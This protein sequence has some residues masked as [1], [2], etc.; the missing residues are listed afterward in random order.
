MDGMPPIGERREHHRAYWRANMR[1][2]AVLLAIWY[3]ASYLCGIVLAKPLHDARIG[4]LPLSFWFGH[5]GS[6]VIFVILIFAYAALMDRL[7]RKH[8]VGEDE[9]Q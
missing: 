2:I 4:M 6:M 9:E 7:D 3:G 8:G 5:Q 1:L